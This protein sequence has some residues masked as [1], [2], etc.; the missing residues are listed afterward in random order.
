MNY[1]INY[2]KCKLVG[3][4]ADAVHLFQWGNIMLDMAFMLGLYV[5]RPYTVKD[6]AHKNKSQ[7]QSFFYFIVSSI[8]SISDIIL[9]ASSQSPF[10]NASW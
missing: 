9:P 1:F 8:S 3:K 5:V 4:K 7:A 2:E 10:D 6:C